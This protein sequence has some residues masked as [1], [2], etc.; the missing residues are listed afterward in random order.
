MYG[1]GDPYFV[2]TMLQ[3]A[4][5]RNGTLHRLGSGQALFQCSYAGN[6][7]WAHICA[8]KALQSNDS[9]SGL[10]YFVND[11]NPVRNVFDFVEPFLQVRG[12][13]LSSFRLPFSPLYH[14]FR[15]LQGVLWLI[16]KICKI[17]MAISPAAILYTNQSVYFKRKLAEEKLSYKPKYNYSESL[18]KSLTFYRNV[19]L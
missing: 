14:M 3:Q 19:S 1:E 13:H 16:G 4:N 12:F 7:A 18:E 17:N 5:S 15:L 9:V 10:A 11:D 2:T 6:V 8:M